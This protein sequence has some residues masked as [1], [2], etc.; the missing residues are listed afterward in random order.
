[1]STRN[2]TGKGQE[3]DWKRTGKEQ[4]GRER[5]KRKTA[6]FFLFFALFS[7]FTVG[8]VVGR[9]NETEKGGKRDGK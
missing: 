5:K 1:M 9:S 4:E 8:E 2:E 3:R 6:G 7:H